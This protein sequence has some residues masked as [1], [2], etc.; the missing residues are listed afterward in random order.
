MRA[1]A[2]V[3]RGSF[4]PIIDSLLGSLMARSHD[5]SNGCLDTG[6]DWI[7]ADLNVGF[8]EINCSFTRLSYGQNVGACSTKKNV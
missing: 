6:S 5:C 7:G 1:C 8:R 4:I 3:N 2:D